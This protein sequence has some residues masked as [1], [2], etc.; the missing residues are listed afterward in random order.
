MPLNLD[1]TLHACA[2]LSGDLH[3]PLRGIE[4]ERLRTLERLGV[5]ERVV[6][7]EVPP[8]VEYLFTPHGR[9]LVEVLD[10]LEVWGKRTSTLGRSPLRSAD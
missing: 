4:T 10:Q 9:G 1:A 8:H 7:P 5:V 3:R 6:H 2:A